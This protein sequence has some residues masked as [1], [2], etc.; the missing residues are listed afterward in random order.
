[1]SDGAYLKA[2]RTLFRS[3]TKNAE[4]RATK[5][6]NKT[7]ANWDDAIEMSIAKLVTKVEKDKHQVRFH[8][9]STSLCRNL[10]IFDA[11]AYGVEKVNKGNK[12]KEMDSGK[13]K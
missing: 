8:M 6:S 10:D 1:V 11:L 13:S 2:E 3:Y 7:Q 12:K 5:S 4:E 9:C